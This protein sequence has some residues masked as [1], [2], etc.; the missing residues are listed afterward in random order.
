MDPPTIRDP[1]SVS[2]RVLWLHTQRRSG[3]TRSRHLAS[4]VT[5]ASPRLG[6]HNISMVCEYP[7][8]FLEDLPGM[9]PRRE[10][11]FTIELAPRSDAV[12]KNPYRVAPAELQELK[13]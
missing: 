8:V 10:V 13:A 4:V 2:A 9:P 1:S 7:D 12:A 5:S 3:D 6:V 11:E